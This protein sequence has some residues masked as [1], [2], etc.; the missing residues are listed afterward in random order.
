M[1]ASLLFFGCPALPAEASPLACLG[2]SCSAQVREGESSASTSEAKEPVLVMKTEG[3]ATVF[4]FEKAS[5]RV[6]SKPDAPSRSGQRLLPQARPRELL[7]PLRAEADVYDWFDDVKARRGDRLLRLSTLIGM[8]DQL[9]EPR[10]ERSTAI[11][12]GRPY[13]NA[14]PA[15]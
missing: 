5:A 1:G 10:S 14:I 15:R 13:R 6:C 7:P 4:C 11:L 9:C 12:E 8:P 2:S 3:R